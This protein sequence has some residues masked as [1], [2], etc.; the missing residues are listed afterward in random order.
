MF[1]QAKSSEFLAMQSSEAKKGAN[2]PRFGKPALPHF[3]VYIQP[4]PM[5]DSVSKELL[6]RGG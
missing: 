1:G 2:N 5:Y 3:S 6:I 4:K